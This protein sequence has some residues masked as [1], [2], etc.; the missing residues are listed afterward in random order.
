[1]KNTQYPP[2]LFYKIKKIL[3][4]LSK[5]DAPYVYENGVLKIERTNRIFEV[6]LKRLKNKDQINVFY[7]IFSPP[8]QEELLTYRPGSWEE[9]IN[10][11]CREAL[12]KEDELFQKNFSPLTTEEE[13]DLCHVPDVVI[14]VK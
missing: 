13:N 12:Q 4:F 14:P 5:H 2:E 11:A 10:K 1:M 6:N 8:W 3:K 7:L 9:D